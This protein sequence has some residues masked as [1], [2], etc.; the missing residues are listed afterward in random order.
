MDFALFM[1]RYG[2]KILLALMVLM[3][4]AFIGWEVVFKVSIIIKGLGLETG[5]AF[6]VIIVLLIIVFRL[7]EQES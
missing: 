5:G 3:I 2:Y 6:L 4:T 1:E 7:G